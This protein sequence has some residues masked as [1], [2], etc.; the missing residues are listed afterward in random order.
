M[1]GDRNP[2]AAGAALD[3]QL[4]DQAALARPS[5]LEWV[6]I[7]LQDLRRF[8]LGARR[9]VGGAARTWAP[10]WA[11]ELDG[12]ARRDRSAFW[13]SLHRGRSRVPTFASLSRP[14]PPCLPCRNTCRSTSPTCCASA[15]W[16]AERIEYKAGCNPDAHLRTLCAFANDFQNLGGGYVVIGQ[17]CDAN[18]QPLV[19]PVGLPTDQ[20]GQGAAGAAGRLPADPATVLS[21]AECRDGR[22][23]TTDRAAGAGRHEPAYKAPASVS[24]KHKSWH[25]YIRRFSSTVEAKGDTSVNC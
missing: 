16:R 20:S 24:A 7:G 22:E 11:A 14:S 1:F 25:Y 9:S 12:G 4:P 3:R 21:R 5:R 17:D 23:P 18:G 8:L 10:G 13:E 2:G 6:Q 15:R 19:P